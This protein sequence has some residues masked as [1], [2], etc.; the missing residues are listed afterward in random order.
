MAEES[1]YVVGPGRMGL[2]L[3]YAL[4]RAGGVA[5]LTVS[6][7]TPRPPA[8][9]LFAL[10]HV[11][12]VQGLDAPPEETTALILAVPD[13]AVP[14]VAELLASGGASAAGG[15]AALHLSG[16][17]G[18]E[19]LAPLRDRGYAVGSLH[20]LQAVADPVTGAD[21]LRGGFYSVS[22]DS[23]AVKVAR[24]IVDRLQGRSLELPPEGKGLYHA[25]AVTASNHL[26]TL[27]ASARNLLLRAGASE[28]E[29][30]DVLLA[31]A[32]GTLDNVGRLGAEGA[33]TGPLRRGDVE[34]VD[35]HLRL[36]DSQERALYAALA[37]E[38]LR[39]LGDDVDPE[40]REILL[41]RLRSDEDGR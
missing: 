28:E 9:P 18:T 27:M 12:Y 20:P 31:L 2:A 26:V 3:G 25:A 15:A 38:T 17:L 21:G 34:T 29:A 7:R 19:G 35:L 30:L 22:G 10:E 40:R 6:G 41:E 32:R 14:A 36:L 4:E 37:R 11:R 24:R 5:R 39:L 8:H 1:L 13:D 33:L 16:A 23:G